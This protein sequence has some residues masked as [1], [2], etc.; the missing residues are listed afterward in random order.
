MT[1]LRAMFGLDGKVAVVTGA[2]GQLGSAFSRALADAGATVLRTDADPGDEIDELD[3][4]DEASVEAAIR[5]IVDR[6]GRIDVLVN[7][8][9]VG[10]YTPLAERTVDEVERV[11]RV[12]VTGTILCSRAA[13]TVMPP[14]GSIVNVASIY[15]LVSPDPRIYGSSGRNSSEVYGASKAGVVQLTRWFAVEAAPSGVRVNSITPGGVFAEQEPGFVAAYGD[16]TPLGR[17]ASPE[18]LEAGLLYLASPGSS[19][20]T[21]HN[22]VIDGGLTAW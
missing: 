1:D 14:G 7:N 2:A 18:D 10:V 5:A 11:L 20:V 9:G 6:H 4:T 12:N 15:G 16:R 21:G 17:M 3:V 22:L 8:A 19:Y 13:L